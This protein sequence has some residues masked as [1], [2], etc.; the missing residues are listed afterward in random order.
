MKTLTWKLVAPLT[1]ISFVICTKWWY[2]SVDG[3][4]E[5]LTGF[6]LPYICPCW[7]TSMCSQIFV[8]GLIID[9]LTYF[10]FWLIL[11]FLINQ[12]VATI[13]LKKIMTIILLSLSGL[14]S[15]GLI[16]IGSLSDNIYSWK[17]EF[18]IEKMET[19]YKF[20]WEEQKRPEFYKY[21]P[22]MKKE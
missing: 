16:L 4:D 10:S 19:G 3:F 12:F 18:E 20:I 22:E 14:L 17:M 13:R 5:I 15:L 7:H 2:V 1:I 9:L 6:P 11:I 21:H 8:S